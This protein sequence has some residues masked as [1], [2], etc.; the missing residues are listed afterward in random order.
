MPFLELEPRDRLLVRAAVDAGPSAATAWDEWFRDTDLDDAAYPEGRLFPQVFANLNA[1]GLAGCLPPRMRG[2]YRWLWA[3]NQM[4]ADAVAPALRAL[5]SAGV[6][7]LLL[8]GAALLA[9][10]R[11]GW[12]TREMGD[13]DVLV[14]T[15]QAG[16]AAA[17]LV[18]AGWTGVQGVTPRY[19]AARLVARRHGWNFD[20][21]GL[22]ADID[23]HWHVFEGVRGL[24]AND[25]LWSAAR[26]VAFAGVDTERLDDADHLVH[27]LEHAS[28]GEATQRLDWLV[29]VDS[30]LPHVDPERFVR[31]A[32]SMSLVDV[33]TEGLEI[34]AS[35]L[36]S[37]RA[38][39]LAQRMASTRRDV[40]SRLLAHTAG[41][42]ANGAPRI[43]ELVR[44][45]LVQAGGGSGPLGRAAA[46]RRRRVEPNL[47]ARPALSTT[48]ALLGR[49]RRAEVAALRLWGP[50]TRSDPRT[51]PT[52]EWIAI[53]PELLDAIGGPGWSWPAPD[54]GGVWTDGSEA[55]LA[56]DIGPVT[57]RDLVLGFELGTSAHHSPNPSVEL[58][59][60]GRALETWQLGPE[61]EPGPRHVAVPAWLADW[62]RPMEMVLRPVRAFE[63][64]QRRGAPGDQ[65]W[66]VQLRALR[67]D[68]Q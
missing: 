35:V 23:L 2:K 24:H 8:K 33:A 3:S 26:P 30:L 60:N 43:N 38:E 34:A 63:P 68:V 58:R 64:W 65:R 36:A 25:E 40:R 48:L 67:V 66:F 27:T 52:G 17:V 49:P 7:T 15:T 39:L 32:T 62:C 45:A 13:I 11:R 14:P 44:T 59:V 16:T 9:A 61:P 42:S 55:R 50:L 19:L 41:P 57:G 10:N 6:K 46:V 29:D 22:S 18:D 28:H 21:D 56:L 47:V 54:G 4:R 53:T 31:V 5:V 37:E 12:G 1:S 51:L 20:G